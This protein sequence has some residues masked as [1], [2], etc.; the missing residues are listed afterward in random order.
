M[1]MPFKRYVPL[2]LLISL[3]G[4]LFS[5]YS[6]RDKTN[7]SWGKIQVEGG[8]ISGTVNASGDVQIFKGIPYAAPPVGAL[9]WKAPQPIVPWTGEKK[10]VSFSASPMQNAPV[11]FGPWT[12]EWLIPASPIS[13]DCL[14]L[15]LWTPAHSPQEKK[16]VI[17]WIYGGAFLSGGAA[18]PIYDGEAM[19]RKGLVFVS[20]N[21]RV[22][23][24]GFLAHPELTQESGTQSSGNYA[25]LDQ[26]AALQWVKKNI[27]AFGGDPDNVTIAGQSAGS[28]SVNC[29]VASPRC[30]GLF[31]RAIAESG[32][33]VIS[34]SF[35]KTH[36]LQEAEAEGLKF[37]QSA[38][39]KSM[40]DLRN[41]PADDL[42]KKP[43][44][45]WGPIVDG[46]VLPQTIA[47]IFAA[48]K[49]NEVSL[50]TGWNEDDGVVF[51][52]MNTAAEFKKQAE[53]TYGSQADEFL[54]YYPASSDAE[55]AS[56][57]LRLSRDQNFGIENYSWASLQADQGKNKTFLYRFSR[58]LPATGDYV[59][60]AAFHSG[61]IPYA[62]DNLS[63][64]HRCP[65]TDVD[66]SLAKTMSSY[67]ANF[68]ATG[69]PNGPGLPLWPVYDTK[70]FSTMVLG[71]TISAKSLPD[72][73]A[74]DFLKKYA[75]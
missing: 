8:V 32:A 19:S 48:G 20:I 56:S 47:E 28:M 16:P 7:G 62:Y 59:K 21:Y 2:G 23:V 27:S 67:W 17:V 72:R 35:M 43:F 46:W 42:Q 9:R 6:F 61:E 39:A 75:K 73:E 53:D 26:I 37:M 68:V 15:N 3:L 38:N 63:F 34:N 33:R 50:L 74:I 41:I 55:A 24:F 36:T 5:L 65:W 64:V 29:L 31:K 54:K 45:R 57:Q 12:E 30:R 69:D 10:C 52:K 11:P 70:S 49:E 25:L 4:I 14:Y 66:Y 13:E 51:G 58:A 60:F 18:V 22:G 44:T 40:A 71:N 1:P